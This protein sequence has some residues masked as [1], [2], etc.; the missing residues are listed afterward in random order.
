LERTSDRG[1]VG[2]IAAAVLTA[3]ALV[4][5]VVQHGGY[6]LSAAGDRVCGIASFLLLLGFLVELV[7]ARR[8]AGDGASFLRDRSLDLAAHGVLVVL[9][10]D[11]LAGGSVFG[12]RGMAGTVLAVQTDLALLFL[13]RL[14]R[15]FRL[16]ARTRVG[17]ARVFVFSFVAIILAGT[18][19]LWALPGTRAEGQAPLSFVDALFTSTSATCV[20]GLVVRDTGAQ[21]SRFGQAV[22]LGLIQVGGLG[23]MTFAAFF[24]VALGQGFGLRDRAM[25]KDMLNVE[26]L[27]KTTRILVA[28]VTIT[29][30]CE[31]LGALLLY[32]R[33]AGPLGDGDR[34]WLSV[35]HSVSA[36]CNAGFALLGPDSLTACRGD[37]LLMGVVSALIVVGGL[38]FVVIL[39]LVEYVPGLRRLLR[40]G[41]RTGDRPPRR[42]SVQT[43]VVLLSS[44]A[45][46][47]VGAV[48]FGLFEAG[49]PETLGSMPAGERIEASVFQSVTSRTAGF[50]TVDE[51]S[52]RPASSLLTMLLMFIG[53]SP[54]STGG[55][56]KT[57]TVVVVLMTVLG[58]ARGRQKPEMLGRSIPF[59]LV[60]R[61]VV[62]LSA[63]AAL[64]LLTL[65]A[66]TLTEPEIPFL[67]LAFET[68]SAFGTVGL[69]MGV[70]ADLSEAGRVILS[71]AMLVGRI[72]PMT[73]VVAMAQSR[74]RPEYDFPEARLMIG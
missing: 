13:V 73:L 71:V 61:A 25:V 56:I 62:I 60:S 32:G 42:L 29:F 23:L 47:V 16:L 55:G 49:N 58:Y 37:L 11:L 51:K 72:G 28:I 41:T 21:F 74:T 4:P 7:A 22:I 65:L 68:V 53:A 31:A 17:F 35:F 40:P 15:L 46:L 67:P 2:R 34:A 70:T 69:S 38:G 54:G 20:T 63:Y 52:M 39:D 66:L 64:N 9:L 45:L 5:W 50:N 19:L 14:I 27:G 10:V 59:Q 43:R 48:G 3:L 24:A 18:V 30:L 1:A 8:A 26:V 44:A 6:G 12:M 33:W 36:F 57:V